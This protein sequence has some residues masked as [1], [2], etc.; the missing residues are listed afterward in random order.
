M[1]DLDII[2]DLSGQLFGIDDIDTI[3]SEAREKGPIMVV[4]MPD[5]SINRV[6]QP[7]FLD[8]PFKNIQG[9]PDDDST[10]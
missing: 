8:Q 9:Y 1:S 2:R 5:G 7:S 4:V 10:D 3:R 6:Q